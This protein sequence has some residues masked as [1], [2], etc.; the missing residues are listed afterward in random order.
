M[1]GYDNTT[2]LFFGIF[3]ALLLVIVFFL[4]GHIRDI[5][6]GVCQQLYQKDTSTYLKCRSTYIEKNIKLIKDISDDKRQDY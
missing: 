5:N 3:T 6:S 2:G 1:I 4:V